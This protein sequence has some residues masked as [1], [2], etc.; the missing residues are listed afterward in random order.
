MYFSTGHFC[1]RKDHTIF[2]VR[3]FVRSFLRLFV[4]RFFGWWPSS[5]WSWVFRYL[6]NI[7]SRA[8]SHR[9]VY[10]MEFSPPSRKSRMH[11]DRPSTPEKESHCFWLVFA[12][13]LSLF[14]QQ[15]PS[16]AEQIEMGTVTR[17]SDHFGTHFSL[18]LSLHMIG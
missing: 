5:L 12:S 4:A 8:Q 18:S 11:E 10:Q 2:I 1:L 16:H 14:F 6:L 17:L 15:L 3:S 13:L 9:S 7:A